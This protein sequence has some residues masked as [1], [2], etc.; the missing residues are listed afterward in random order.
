MISSVS[1][2]AR[3]CF[4]IAPDRIYRIELHKGAIY[5]LRTGGQFDLDRGLTQARGLEGIAAVLVLATG[6]A[7]LR[8]HK[9]EELIA[10][11]PGTDPEALLGIH[12]HNS[13]LVPS[14]I[15]RAS[16]LPKKWFL[17]LFRHHFGRL[18]LEPVHGERREYHFETLADVQTAYA[19]LPP[20]L[21][22]KLDMRIHWDENGSR[23]LPKNE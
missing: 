8:N 21:G 6:E 2:N 23:F 19:C 5:F 4:T 22:D 3:A 18:L 11:D 16:L 1:F 17:A 13:K 20:L 15:A 9:K 10:R 14:D 12:P 7:L